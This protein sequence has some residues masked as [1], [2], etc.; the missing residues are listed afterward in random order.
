M[1]YPAAS[2]AI[3]YCGIT[4]TD[5]AS[6]VGD[7]LN[8]AIQIVESTTGRVFAAASSD[9]ETKYFDAEL[10]VDGQTLYLGSNDLLSV[11]NDTDGNP[12]IDCGGT[13]TVY[14]SDVIYLPVNGT[15]KNAIK[16]R[17]DSGKT[18]TWENDPDDA[19]SVKGLWAYSADPPQDI[20]FAIMRL[21]KWMYDQ[22]KTT[23]E[24]DRPLLTESGNI[25]MPQKLP[26]DVMSVLL[27]YRKIKVGAPI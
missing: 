24:I 7:I 22:R 11:S 16:L 9:V 21:C 18:W 20:W 19:L 17:G 25:I 4:D 27:H 15:P 8:W 3:A 10:D 2:D 23:N 26:Q 5:H 14:A 13:D 6:M 12:V 1:G